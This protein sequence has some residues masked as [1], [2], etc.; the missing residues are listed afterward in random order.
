MIACALLP[1][2]WACSSKP[3][4]A[5][6]APASQAGMANPA[7]AAAAAELAA[8]RDK[9]RMDAEYP[10]HGLVTG[11]QLKVR[12]QPDP[13]ALVIGWLRI[14]SRVRLAGEPHKTAT[15]SSGFYRLHPSG[16]A[17]AGEGIE[18][19]KTPPQ[20]ELAA[21]PPAQDAPLPY[22]YYL[23]KEPKVPEYHRLPSRDEQR[24][25]EAF[26]Q[27]YLEL[28]LKSEERPS[29]SC[30]ASSRAK[31]PGRTSCAATSI[32]AS[33]SPA[34]ASRCARRGSS[35]ARCAAAT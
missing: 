29:S 24:A 11:A 31:R 17:C 13:D 25:V 18:V 14:G 30:A 34:P 28:K 1:C 5:G 15:C 22:A 2:A 33:S 35:C 23:I 4:E 26:V 16:Y 9:K 6:V 12:A 32:A 21:N 19:A 20:S 10:L 8:E 3:S 27:H 7:A